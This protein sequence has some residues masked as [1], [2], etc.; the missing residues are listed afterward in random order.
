MQIATILDNTGQYAEFVHEDTTKEVNKEFPRLGWSSV[1][2]CAFASTI[3]EEGS[4]KPWCH[5]TKM[6]VEAFAG[7]IEGN[8]IMREFE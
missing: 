3:R 4:V 1:P 6:G 5:T 8:E 7:G 2:G